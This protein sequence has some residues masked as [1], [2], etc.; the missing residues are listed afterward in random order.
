MVFAFYFQVPTWLT[1]SPWGLNLWALQHCN[2]S[3][4]TFGRHMCLLVM[5]CEPHL[6]CTGWLLFPLP[7][8]RGILLLLISLFP[9]HSSNMVL[10]TFPIP[11]LSQCGWGTFYSRYVIHQMTWSTSNLWWALN[12][13]ILVWWS[14][15]RLKN[16]LTCGWWNV[17][18]LHN[19]FI[20]VSQVMLINPLN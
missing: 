11:L 14:G 9:S 1:H 19:T 3:K 4:F 10:H 17:S 6:E 18:L 7:L 16:I 8:V 5:V 12:L 2:P 13:G 20:L 15:I